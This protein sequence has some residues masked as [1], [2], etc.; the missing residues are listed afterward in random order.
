MRSN[1][2]LLLLL[3]PFLVECG[4]GP[5]RWQDQLRAISKAGD[6]QMAIEAALLPYDQKDSLSLNFRVRISPA[7]DVSADSKSYKTD[8][9]YRMDSC[10]YIQSGYRKFYPQLTQAVAGGVSK[11]YEYLVSFD[12][13]T[14]RQQKGLSL[15]YRDRYLN[16][17]KYSLLLK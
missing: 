16:K 5:K 3:M 8:L 12:I 15:I 14:L 17:R 11:R 7:A 9:L 6:S 4:Y 10:F 13:R 2:V 1:C